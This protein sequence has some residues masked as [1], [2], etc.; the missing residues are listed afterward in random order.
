MLF[1]GIDLAWSEKNGSG[2]AILKG[3]KNNAKFISADICYSDK[4]I[5][6]YVERNVGT[7]NAFIAIDAPLI[8]PNKKG[9]RVAEK[10]VGILFRR[11]DAGAHPANRERLSRWSGKIRGEEIAKKLEKMGFSHAPYIKRFEE[12][13]KFFEVYPHPSMVVIFN[14][15]K[16]LKYKAKP[17]R[18]YKLRW[19]EFRA[20]QKHLKN[21]EKAEPALFLPEEITERDVKEM[22]G[23]ALKDYEDLLDAIFC[24]YIA[25]Y[26]WYYPENCE[27]L[28]DMK[29]GYILTPV[30]GF[31][32]KR[33]KSLQS[34]KKLID[35]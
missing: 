26:C 23:R 20:Y 10:L 5:I 13:R 18:D 3:D 12:S 7:R 30:F 25:Y 17:K 31:M 34:Q 24:A 1:V 28:G 29:E 9:R 15:N 4:E 19:N 2:I 6:K 8:V 27:I 22:K 14:L 11:Y 32:K 33:L 16:V 35:F 21:L